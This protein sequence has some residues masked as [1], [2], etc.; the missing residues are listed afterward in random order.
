VTVCC[1]DSNAQDTLHRH[2]VATITPIMEKAAGALPC[3]IIKCSRVRIIFTLEFGLK[4]CKLNALWFFGIAFGFCDLVDHAR[5]H[6]FLSFWLGNR[7]VYHLSS[8]TITVPLRTK[9]SMTDTSLKELD[10]SSFHACRNNKPMTF[11]TNWDVAQKRKWMSPAIENF[12]IISKEIRTRAIPLV[13]IFMFLRFASNCN[14]QLLWLSRFLKLSQFQLRLR[15]Q[16][17]P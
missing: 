5:I 11:T 16:L 7:C 14:H 8:C 15:T 6:N 9:S 1:W 17:S 2:S 13:R 10:E 12:E 4:V 3:T